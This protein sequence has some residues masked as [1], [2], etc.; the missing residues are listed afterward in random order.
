MH[1]G[2]DFKV[3]Y[4]SPV[5]SIQAGVIDAVITGCANRSKNAT[6]RR[7]GGG[8]G[9]HVRIRHPDGNYSY[10]AHMESCTALRNLRVGQTVSQGQQI[11]CV[12]SSGG[13]TGPHL[14]LEIRVGGTSK[15][16]AVDPKRYL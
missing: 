6:Q 5:V 12:G 8:F 11:G 2:Q 7:C 3:S 10:Y 4:G 14:H 15:S 13:S 9:N 1:Y 16:R